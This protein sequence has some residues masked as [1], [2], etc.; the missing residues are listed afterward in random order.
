MSKAILALG[1]MPTNLPPPPRVP[2]EAYNY[3]QG[4]PTAS[5]QALVITV[6]AAPESLIAKLRAHTYA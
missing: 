3:T 1:I 2:N 5:A 6:L 4:I